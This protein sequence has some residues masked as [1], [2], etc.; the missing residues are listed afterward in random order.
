MAL[1]NKEDQ[2][3]SIILHMMGIAFVEIRTANDIRTCQALADTFHNV[4]ARISRG[5]DP[6]DIL[7]DIF[8]TAKRV[9]IEEYIRKLHA[10]SIKEANK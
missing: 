4:P 5:F 8:Q 2:K 7:H 6:D 10:H 3:Y 9:K 1:A